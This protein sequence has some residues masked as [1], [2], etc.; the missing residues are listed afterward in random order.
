MSDT[1]KIWGQIGMTFCLTEEEF[2]TLQ[3]GGGD[4]RGSHFPESEKW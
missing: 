2:H 4:A 1:K 3:D